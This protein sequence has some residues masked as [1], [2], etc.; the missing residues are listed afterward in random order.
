[1]AAR[2]F[3]PGFSRKRNQ[4]S[5]CYAIEPHSLQAARSPCLM[6]SEFKE[7]NFFTSEDTFYSKSKSNYSTLFHTTE[8]NVECTHSTIYLLDQEQ[9]IQQY[10]CWIRSKTFNNICVGSGA[11]HSTIYLLDHIMCLILA[12]NAIFFHNSYDN[13][14][15]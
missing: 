6:D 1:M 4:H 12:K 7:H 3:K 15:C 11:Q 9:N 2:G 5:N 14:H 13:Y 10:I 8:H